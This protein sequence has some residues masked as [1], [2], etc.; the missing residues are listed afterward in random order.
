MPGV[1]TRRDYDTYPDRY[2]LGTWL[3]A[4]QR[5][6][7]ADLHAQIVRL[8]LEPVPCGC[9]M[10]DRRLRLPVARRSPVGMTRGSTDRDIVRYR[11]EV[12]MPDVLI[13][14]VPDGVVA[15]IDSRAAQLGMSR[16]EYLR[17]RLS[18]DAQRSGS[19]VGVDDLRRFEALFGDLTDPEVMDQAWS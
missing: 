9:S 13:R 19:P 7:G 14:D 16:N 18:Q 6:P 15:A 12:R 3:T 11:K 2:R 4:A 5:A 1:P 8:L 17:R 10:I